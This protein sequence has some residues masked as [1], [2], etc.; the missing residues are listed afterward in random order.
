MNKPQ[1]QLA[2]PPIRSSS[3]WNSLTRSPH[4]VYV[5][6]A[7]LFLILLAYVIYPFFQTFRQSLQLDGGFSLQNYSRFFSLEHTANLEALWTSVYISVLSVITCGIV[8]VAMAFLLERYEF[9]GRKLLSVLVLVPMALPPLIGVLSFEFL[10]GSSGIIPRGLQHLLHL[11]KPPFTLKGIWGV[12]VVH[13]FTMYTYFYMTASSA[14][15][16]LDPS[17][18]EAAANLGANRFTIWRRVILPC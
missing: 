5:L 4:F 18:E 17:L 14:I 15:K 8:G 9:P 6:I 7:P 16:G 12:L 13:T 2:P 11:D 10:Y 3:R 1:P